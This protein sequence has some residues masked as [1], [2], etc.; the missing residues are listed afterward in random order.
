MLKGDVSTKIICISSLA[1]LVDELMVRIGGAFDNIRAVQKTLKEETPEFINILPEHLI[2]IQHLLFNL[3]SRVA[4]RGEDHSAEIPT[5]QEKDTLYLEKFI[6]YSN[7]SLPPL[8]DFVLTGGTPVNTSLHECRVSTRNVERTIIALSRQTNLEDEVL[9]FI[10]RL[11]DLFFVLARRVNQELGPSGLEVEEIIWN[12]T[13][14]EPL[15]P[16]VNQ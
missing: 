6:D 4:T 10:N 11:S 9:K 16:E 14:E 13:Q 15:L 2:Y 3:G 8:K 5:V 7:A 1:G 12:P